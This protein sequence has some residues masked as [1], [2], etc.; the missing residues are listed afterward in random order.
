M[1][2][3]ALLKK[4]AYLS[5][6]VI[7]LLFLALP[8]LLMGEPEQQPGT[9]GS[10]GALI[11][12][13][14]VAPDLLAPAVS[15]SAGQKLLLDDTYNLF[16]SNV[17]EMPA[18]PGILCRADDVLPPSGMVRV[19]L[20]HLNLLID[21]DSYGN[22]QA[23][24]GF[25]VENR[26]SRRLD[27][28][29]VR[30]AMVVSRAPDGT[31]IF[32]EDAAPVRPGESEPLYYGS[33]VGNYVVQ[34][35][36]L[37]ETRPPEFLGTA[38]PG[39]RVIVSAEVGPRGWVA[40]LYDLK[41]VDAE[42]GW[43]VGK[44]NLSEGEEVGIETFIAPLEYDINSFLDELMENEAVLPLAANDRLHM[45]GLFRPGY[46][47]DNPDGEAVSKIFTVTYSADVGWPVSFAL[48]AGEND[49]CINPA[50]PNYTADVFL[51]DRLRNGYDPADED[52]KGVNGGNYGVGYTVF[53]QLSGPAALVLQG[54]LHKGAD[55]DSAFIDLYNQI[56]TFW[57]DGR[58]STIQFRDPQYDLY[59]KNISAL[60]PLGQGRVIGIFPNQGRHD[61][62][63]R[64]SLPPNCYGPVRF[65]LLPLKE[66]EKC[67]LI[68]F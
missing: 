64:F 47:P 56:L 10:A 22:I 19:L 6:L 44:G 14:E 3:A 32:L 58:V 11:L 41:F 20:S 1:L 51:N 45:R 18:D 48:A 24:A 49:Q 17:P 16:F 63:L 38:P 57:L 36:F 15:L 43:Q 61:H 26:T 29:A 37:S 59:Y 55:T 66:Q 12:G 42:T 39:G 62:L 35:W 34:Q 23:C 9:L 67:P 33:A 5:L 54:A 30:G 28:Y 40:G 68:F 52:K 25:A 27:I 53:L 65:Y 46:Y 31:Y 60:R 50:G 7:L 21:W 2:I 4:H 8:P 13:Q